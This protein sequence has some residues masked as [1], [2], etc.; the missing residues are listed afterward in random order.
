MPQQSS[1]LASQPARR[2]AAASQHPA[3]EKSSA[4][5]LPT[6]I[7]EDIDNG[8]YE[9]VICT[10]EVVRASRVWSCTI[11]WTVAHLHC[12][13]KWHTNQTK[14]SD[15]NQN[16]EPEQVPTWRCPGC[17]SALTQE[18][19][20]YHCWCAKDIN[21]RP[22]PG[23]SPHSCGQTCSKPRPNCPHLC[24]LMCHAGPCPPCTMM[25]PAQ[26]CFCGKHTSTKK[27]V[28]T[29]YSKGFSCHEICGDLLPCGEHT[30]SRPCHSGLCGGCDIPVMSTCYCGREEHEIPCNQRDEPQ[31]SFNYGQLLSNSKDAASDASDAWFDG[32]FRCDRIC[33]R[34]FDCG[35]HA[36]EQFCHAQDEAIAHCHFAPDVVTNCPCGKTPLE[37]LPNGF[38]A[39]CQVPIQHCNEACEKLLLCGHRCIEK[40]H[41]GAC[42][43]CFQK[44]DMSCRCGRTSSRSVC[45]GDETSDMYKPQCFRICRA[46]L[47]CGRHECGDHCC[48]GEKKAT[49]RRKQKRNAAENFEAE[50][51]CLQVCGRQLKC[52]K[53][54]CQQLCHKGACNSCVEAIFEEI[55][56][57]CGRTVLPPLQ[58]CGTKPP[59]C[60]YECTR[61]PACGHPTVS[62]QCHPEEVSCPKCPFLVEKACICGKQRL[63]NQRCWFDEARCGLPCGEKLKCG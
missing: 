34:P 50:H 36:C 40:C 19:G 11:C 51:I 5:D 43:P 45:H 31:E 14:N 21:P 28:E 16:Q 42:P 41:T 8:Q 52:G 44:M 35:H 61:S 55:G 46:T 30:C 37:S 12:V 9:C 22:I 47:N 23:L 17:N 57:A 1:D 27:C 38:R 49:E 20:S 59:E 33:G 6:R 29:D 24:S 62:H 18:P 2:Q 32:S 56:C 48:P 58:P 63:K 15:Q 13:K 26:I 39:D 25:G 60:R 54:T 4:V 7:H 3:A 10:S 53:H